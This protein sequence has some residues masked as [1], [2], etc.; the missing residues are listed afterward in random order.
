MAPKKRR[1][2][3]LIESQLPGFI[4][5]EYENFSKFIEKYYEHQESFGQPIN[6][7]SNLAK[8]RDI[9]TYEKNLL[10]QSTTLVA[11]IAADSSS[12]EL[13]DASSFP[14]ENGYI[15]IGEEILFYQSRSG[16]VLEEVSRGV[17]GNTTLGD[18]YHSSR[19]V[20]T[21]SAPHY[22]GDVVYNISNLFLYALVKEFEKT[23]LSSFPEAYLKEDV[24]KRLLIKNISKFYKSKGTD[25]SVK[26]LFNSVVSK[27]AE[28][29][30]EVFNP[31]DQT[32][33]AS[34]SDWINDGF[35]KVRV[36]SGNPLNL[37]GQV[38]SQQADSYTG[39]EFASA[40]V[41]NVIFDGN[42]GQD[43]IYKLILEPSTING[44]FD[45]T[46]RTS[47]TTGVVPSDA[48]GDRITVK[49]TLGF[50]NSGKILIGEEVFEY[51]QKTV[52]QFIISQRPGPLRSHASGKSVYSYLDIQGSDV[53][54]ISLGMVYNFTPSYTA[55]YSSDG[56]ALEVSKAGFETLDPIVNDRWLLNTTSEFARIKGVTQ[57][58]TGDVSG[59]F[60]DDQYYY[61]A[62]S[63]FPNENVLVDTS[64]SE[65]LQDQKNLKLIRKVPSTT[66]EVYPT[67]NR[68]VG[69]FIDGVP[70]L[71]YRDFDFV[72]YGAIEKVDI[73]NKGNSYVN[74]PFVLLNERTNLARCTLAGSTINEIE[75]LTQEAFDDDPVIRITSGEGAVLSPVVTNGAITSMTVIE[76]GK[77]Y[78][79]PPVIRIVDSLGRGAFAEF[80][81]IIDTNGSIEEVK[82]I[83]SGRFYTS[84]FVNVSVEA[85]GRNASATCEIKKWVYDRY[86]RYKTN[87]D[88]FNGTILSSF[89]NNRGFGYGYVANPVKV[90]ERAYPT[91]A[92]Y[93]ANLGAENT[94]SPIIGYAYDGNPIYGPYGYENPTDP[95]STITRL[96]SGYQ[97][98]SGRPNGPD[99][100]RYPIGTFIDDYTWTPSVQSGKRE[101]DKNNGR[102]CITPEYPEGTY[103]Y[104]ITVSDTNGTPAFPYILGENYYSLPVDSNY[105]SRISQDDIPANV[106]SI[107]NSNSENNGVGFIGSILNTKSGNITSSYVEQSTEYFSPGNLLYTNDSNTGGSGATIAVNEVTGKTVSS[108]ESTQTKAVQINSVEQ[109]YFFEG[110]LLQQIGTDGFSDAQGTL[111]RDVVN[112]NNFV[113]RN[114]SGDFVVAEGVTLQ[115]N[116]LVQRLVL[117]INS[118]FTAGASIR[119][120]DDDDNDVATGLIL[121]TTLRQNSVIVKVDAGNRF[122]TTDEY[123]LRSSNLSDTNRAEVIS[124]ESLSENINA[125]KVDNN[126]AI[127]ETSENH[128]LGIDD[129]VD[130]TIFPDDISTTTTY[131][132]R[133]R[134]YQKAIV[135][136][137]VHTSTIEDQ[138]IGRFDVL[139]SGR[140]YSL[141]TYT[142]VELVFQDSSKARPNIGRA[143]DAYNAKATVIVSN[144]G[145]GAV[146]NVIITDKGQGYRQGDILAV[147]D[148]SLNRV[149][150]ETSSQRLVLEVAHVGLA[151]DNTVVMLSNV[152]SIS[153]EDFLQIGQEIVKISAVDVQEKKVT[154]SRGEQGTTP[155]DHFYGGEVKLL[156]GT[157]K[158][159]D[160]FRPFGEGLTR[161]YLLSYDTTTNE[162]EVA[163]DYGSANPQILSSSSSFFDNS[164]PQKL[165]SFRSV[166]SKAFN[167]EFSTDDVNFTTNP[168]IDIQK[169]YRYTFD[170]SHF[171]MVNTFLDFSASANY[172]IFTEEKEVSS[173]SPGSAGAFVSIKLGFGPATYSNNYQNEVNLNFQNYFY[174]I[175]ASS[176]VDTNQSYLRVIDD[177]LIGV[178]KVT[179]VTDTKFVYAVDSTPAYDG[180]GIM[181]YVTSSLQAIGNIDSLK[182]VNSGSSY[183]LIPTVIG[184][185]PSQSFRAEA[186]P[187]WDEVSQTIVGFDIIDPGRNYSKPA[188]VVLE[189]DGVNYEFVCSSF[190]GKVTKIEVVKGGSG[191]TF[192]PTITIVE[193]DLTI[194][195][196]SDNIG[197]PKD[198]KI[199]DPGKGFNSDTSQL[200]SYKSPTTFVLRNISDQFFGGEVINQASTGASAIVAKNGWRQGS[201][202]LK[203]VNIKG[204]F[205]NN[206]E[207]QTQLGSRTATLYAQLCSEFSPEIRSYVDNY[208]FYTSD[209]GKLSNNNQRL[210]DSYYYQDYSYVLRSKTSIEVWR[211]LI[212]E[213]THPAGFQLF[214]EMVVDSQASTK[215]PETQLSL[216]HF[217]VIELPPVQITSISSRQQVTV[218]QQKVENTLI[219]QGIGSVS[220]DT[221]DT[222]ETLTFDVSL[223][224]DFNGDFDPNTGQLTGNKVFTLVDK[225]SGNALTL[226]RNEELLATLDGVFQEPGLAYTINGSTITFATPPFG[227]RVIEGQDVSAVRF[228]GRA[229]KF[230][231]PTLNTRY[232]RKIK[233]ISDQFDGKKFE[234]ELLWEE[235]GIVKT[236][237]SENLIVTLNGVVQKARTTETEPFGNSYSIIRSDDTNIAD[238]IRFS[239]PPIDNE[240]LYGPPEELPEELKAY[241]KCAIY[242]VGSYERLKIN[243]DLYEYRFG[244]PY[245]LLDEVTETVRKVDDSTYAFVF[246][247]GVLQRETDSYQIVGPNITFT[248][249]LQSYEDESG[250]RVAQDV[251]VIL[252]YGRD[253]PRTLTFYDFEPNTFNNV[254]QVTLSGTGVTNTVKNLFEIN[255]GSTRTFFKQGNTLVGKV[256]RYSA[257][258]NDEIMLT[259][260]NPVN[261]SLTETDPLTLVNLDADIETV[262][263]GTY[264]VSYYYE[265]DD[266]GDRILKRRVPSWLDGLAGGN[267]AWSNKNSMFANLVPG[268]R[269][270]IDGESKFRTVVGTPDT[271]KTKNYR[272]NQ[273]AQ[274]DIYAKAVVTDYTGD[275]E[276][277]GLSLNANINQYGEITDL[278]V[279]DIEWN[280][281]DL[282]LYFEQGILLQPTAYEYYT[283]PEIHFIPVDGKGGGAKAEVIAYNGQIIDVVLTEAGSGY[284]VPPKVVVARRYKK[285]KENARKIDSLTVLNIQTQIPGAAITT[286]QTQ[287]TIEGDGDT[288]S[289]FSIISFGASGAADSATVDE[290]DGRVITSHIWTLKDEERQ[291]LMTDEK[292][293]TEAR[294]QS[295][296]VVLDYE[297]PV[298]ERQ[299]TQI[300]GGV[301]GFEVISGVSSNRDL[302]LT[303]ILELESVEAFRLQEKTDSINGVGTFLDA[304]LSE[305]GTIVYVPNTARFPDTPSRI[306]IGREVLFYRE[307][308]D[309]R[310]LSVVR[311]Y[312]NTVVSAHNAGDLVLHDPEF[313]TLISGGVNEIY[314]EVSVAQSSV[315]QI[316]RTSV[317]QSITEIVDVDVIFDEI[318]HEHQIDVDQFNYDVIEQITIIP[319]TSYN[320]VTEIHTSS[321]EIRPI[322]A[323]PRDI[324]GLVTSE[325]VTPIDVSLQLT[326]QDQLEVSSKASINT[327][328]IESVGATAFSTSNVVTS[329][330]ESTLVTNEVTIETDGSLT[331]VSSQIVENVA[332][333]FTSLTTTIGSL[334]EIEVKAAR[335]VPIEVEMQQGALFNSAVIETKLN[336]VDT[337]VTTF[338]LIVGGKLDDSGA[339]ITVPYKFAVVDYLVEEFVLE[340][341]I[342][343]RNQTYVELAD[344]YNEVIRRDGSSI[345][346]E[347]KDQ[348]IPVGFEDYTQGNVGL[349]L[350][351]FQDNVNVDTGLN[352]GLTI[353]ELSLAYPT[354]SIRDFEFRENSAFVGTGDRFNFGIP[355]YQQP[356][357]IS[358]SSGNVGSGSTLFV[359]NT[360]NFEDSGYIFTESGNVIQYTSKTSNSFVG[361]T[362]V[363]G[364]NTISANDEI[365]PFT[366][367]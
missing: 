282:E 338:S 71:G 185:S 278:S 63:S 107:R 95:N 42:D 114:V 264:T 141:G 105:N 230:K 60:E 216:D 363:R 263:P 333:T 362:L 281:R 357:T 313:L 151:S 253:V 45:V 200:G 182:V 293:P 203:V 286:I 297:Q 204:V 169:Y 43:D 13:S 86:N 127:V 291:V 135:L 167:L 38:I 177:P 265:K 25:R 160:G 251:S 152:N 98:N 232:F 172:N 340:K 119:L 70:A 3:S 102:F 41:D 59:V 52:N 322:D 240:D 252:L 156:N 40:T 305:T 295:P 335:V 84:G 125:F 233:S 224:P 187:V 316:E 115:S 103:A 255:S 1:L 261:V 199:G 257:P 191:F 24:D 206:S 296:T 299:I 28:D 50:P 75:I 173:V 337:F 198:I 162:I 79:S 88:S 306:R 92:A 256:G 194:Y 129:E 309:D 147:S 301:S 331:T 126:I 325:V 242:T 250:R 131:Y 136:E 69:I 360:Q 192:K 364:P 27:Q 49:S 365:I 2:S 144:I 343:L 269:I 17:S 163:F 150:N 47:L 254:L 82:K 130:V 284:T 314:T 236:D 85:V 44:T 133:K 298:A 283:T 81:A 33:K 54:V 51:T 6:I 4:T 356:V 221:F 91:S 22:T 268:D 308:E 157:Y 350:G 258:S 179:Y 118:S 353:G 154:I 226:D 34:T 83:S 266:E 153:Q 287:I 78:S 65:D 351:S 312:Q 213:T 220:V 142:D 246:I 294:V 89:E 318:E 207:I 348:N 109:A 259:M 104:F 93:T 159:D 209:R 341:S 231:N 334:I 100:G 346:V 342:L 55:P 73:T 146:A 186:E 304:P 35:L 273:L 275:T 18:L 366:L 48:I 217:T 245:L 53:K 26:F 20:T 271:A 196:E 62:S 241:E 234:F 329:S 16:N 113:L 225:A 358:A 168:V 56:E 145:G 205:K 122:Y 112:D 243:S 176:D 324:S 101:L 36:V 247:D 171:S 143:G 94:H 97:L 132:V 90:R 320:V 211:N 347:N 279:S 8:Y 239:K 7:I 223:T 58:F 267:K 158:F 120:T 178:K 149:A 310:F 339:S 30:P 15:K 328:L 57:K 67:T 12:L 327:T 212:K 170:V 195:L 248:R 354:L 302:T 39:S 274:N 210:Q 244:G 23:Y 277:V 134:L 193:S 300:I 344:P 175:S 228:Y 229:I 359:Q 66:T 311:G 148:D 32:L 123:Y 128:N 11:N 214:G 276:G 184:V 235:G 280:Q 31:K 111:I 270:L 227:D 303:S 110:D 138:G 164:V 96:E 317:I 202:L 116:I 218:I 237:P 307:K 181:S 201:N 72:K 68:D 106:K 219:E 319:P 37:V 290:N 262:V 139:N 10:Q 166:E 292:F 367:V 137:P 19:F 183:N 140:G 336:D 46:S 345:L 76:P 361:C 315:S 64:Y 117:D 108:I 352:S 272:E 260:I 215:M 285:I 332:S 288:N 155:T 80:E 197:L 61:I 222:T 189:G 124:T 208:G 180:S 21:A 321:S 165:V 238:R 87:L 29:I 9:D 99:S 161:P 14:E 174:F 77:Y 74:P 249:P 330:Y 349:T 5:S 188:V 355:S 323:S 190:Q 121:E 326:Q 289:I